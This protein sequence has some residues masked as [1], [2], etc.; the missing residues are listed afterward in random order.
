VKGGKQD[1]T[2]AVDTMLPA[3]SGPRGIDAFCVEPGRWHVRQGGRSLVTASFEEAKAPV[4]TNEQKLA[5][6]LEKDQSKVWAAGEKVNRDLATLSKPE[7][8]TNPA[9]P[10]LVAPQQG[11]GGQ[12]SATSAGITGVFSGQK[13]SYVE[14]IEDAE[15]QKK[16][17]ERIAALE[18]AI[19]GKTDAVGA[20]FCMN[21][22]LR[23]AEIYASAGLFRKLWPKLLRS[24][25]VEAISRQKEATATA[26]PPTDAEVRTMLADLASGK[27]KEEVRSDGQT[28]RI[29]NKE[30]A[31]L[32]DTEVNGK[33][34][35]RQALTK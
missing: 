29:Y 30:K 35:H 12:L 15:V 18:T 5:I 2:I 24:A 27:G 25:S 33:L 20:V 34:L 22:K 10:A 7:A 14:A 1:R 13:N 6:R 8:G 17:A 4:A 26:I 11:G 19:L 23:S 16:L 28:V 3:K 21:G 9:E 32:F 31:V